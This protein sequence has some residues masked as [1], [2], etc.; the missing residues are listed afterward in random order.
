MKSSSSHEAGGE[1]LQTT[2][3]RDLVRRDRIEEA[4]VRATKAASMS[5]KL[6]V[7]RLVAEQAPKE[8]ARVTAFLARDVLAAMPAEGLGQLV[9]AA[10]VHAPNVLDDILAALPLRG[11]LVPHVLEAATKVA[12]EQ[13]KLAILVRAVDL[14]VPLD[15]EQRSAYVS[16]LAI[17]RLLAQRSGEHTLAVQLADRARAFADEH[18]A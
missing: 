5:A 14:P 8:L 16:A 18:L 17:A 10:A 15:R 3:L 2:T 11:G 9:S 7:L 6:R 13:L 4:V 12:D 1:D